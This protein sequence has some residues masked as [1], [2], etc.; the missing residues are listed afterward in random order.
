[1]P[2]ET[3]L[4]QDK[5][6]KFSSR[7]SVHAAVFFCLLG[8]SIIVARK[9]QKHR[10]TIRDILTLLLIGMILVIFSGYFFSA[11]SLYG[12]S[13]EI[14]VSFQTFFCMCLLTFA[15][16]V[17]G[18][19]GGIFS[20]FLGFGI[21]SYTARV[22]LPWALIGPFAVISAIDYFSTAR[23]I[24]QEIQTALSATLLSLMFFFIIL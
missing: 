12:H 7:M 13:T 16:F 11:T 5:Y 4:T 21:A 18:I 15:N 14:L 1:L 23:S 6:A 3:F 8:A 22:S 9:N 24:S 20:L 2:L 19:Q 17:R 10:N